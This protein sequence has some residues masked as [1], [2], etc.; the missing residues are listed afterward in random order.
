[1]RR[2]W[3]SKYMRAALAGDPLPGPI[4]GAFH[5]ASAEGYPAKLAGLPVPNPRPTPARIS[6]YVAAISR[7]EAP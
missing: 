2:R 7:N 4:P 5:L 6:A 3:K 1:M